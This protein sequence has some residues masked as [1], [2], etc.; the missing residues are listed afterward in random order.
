MT[1]LKLPCGQCIG[2]RLDHSLM[3]A[4]RAMHEAKSHDSNCFITLT[5]SDSELPADRSL[6][7]DH[8]T[9][10]MKRLRKSVH[11]HR[12]K[13]FHC[14][15]YSPK[16]ERLIGPS[17]I[18][19]DLIPEGQRP[20]YHALIFGYDFPDKT[21]WSVRDDVHIYT[22]DRLTNLWGKGFCTVGN[23]T[24]ESA[25]YVARYSL[26]KINGPL[27]QKPCPTTGLRP[28]ERVHPITFE[29]LEVEKE[30]VSMSNGIGL[31]FYLSYTDDMYP[32]DTMVVNGYDRRPPRYYDNKYDEEFPDEMEDI[33]KKRV[34]RMRRY[35]HD[36]TT[37]R[38]K[39]R[40]KVKEAQLKML[41][42]DKIQ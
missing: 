34:D 30:F 35:A 42:R 19:P 15:E 12:I 11:P 24:F 1:K 25:A 31:D 28:Y 32:R 40:E 29:I 20:H 2:C 6:V 37:P 18:H 7:K 16:R 38:L 39:A 27:E 33:R 5:Y 8:F 26:K 41:K 13:Y 36:N 9:R 21:L 23:L 10:F 3:W 14:G 4:T 17:K 22:S